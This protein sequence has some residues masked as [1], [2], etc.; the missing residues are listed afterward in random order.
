MD[1]DKKKYTSNVRTSMLN[2]NNS[3]YNATMDMNTLNMQNIILKECKDI[4]PTKE[5]SRKME[6][7]GKKFDITF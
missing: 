1:E 2:G 7:L 4:S 3:F 6:N 5:Q